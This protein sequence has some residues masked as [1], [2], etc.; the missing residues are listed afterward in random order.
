[1]AGYHCILPTRLTEGAALGALQVLHRQDAAARPTARSHGSHSAR[2]LQW[3]SCLS[4]L[5]TRLTTDAHCAAA[6]TQPF[7]ESP[8]SFGTQ[9]ASGKAS[10]EPRLTQGTHSDSSL[11]CIRALFSL[12]RVHCRG[13]QVGS[14]LLDA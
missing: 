14:V 6:G 3:H 7:Y 1:M 2:T 8:S 5:L 12:W 13:V 11:H 4:T 10:P 9:A